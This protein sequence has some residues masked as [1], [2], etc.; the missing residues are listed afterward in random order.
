[1]KAMDGSLPAAAVHRDLRVH[2]GSAGGF[3]QPT[4]QRQQN[5][6]CG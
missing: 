1:M 3:Q 5:V 4:A 2:S 6:R